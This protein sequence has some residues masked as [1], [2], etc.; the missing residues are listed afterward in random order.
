M[1]LEKQAVLEY[2][3]NMMAAEL[4]GGKIGLRCDYSDKIVEM[5]CFS[6]NLYGIIPLIK[7][8]FGQSDRYIDYVKK[9]LV[10]GT[11]PKSKS[12]WG[13]YVCPDQRVCESIPIA[14]VLVFC[15]NEIWNTLN[16]EEKNNIVTWLNQV[17]TGTIYDSNWLFF[18]I[19]VNSCLKKLDVNYCDDLLEDSLIRVNKLYLGNGWYQDGRLRRIDYY[20]A[21]A[22]HFYGLLFAYLMPE[23]KYSTI[24]IERA[25][26]FSQEFILLSSSKGD[27]VP[28]GRSLTYK[29]AE[30]CFWSVQVYTGI[31]CLEPK[32]VKGIIARHFDFWKDKQIYNSQGIIDVGYT[33]LNPFMTEN[34]NNW[35]SS[36]WALKFFL[37]A[38]VQGDD[39]WS[40]TEA[41]LPELPGKKLLRT[42]NMIICS[43]V[44]RSIVT[45]F[46]NNYCAGRE[47]VLNFASKYMK[48][49]Y[50]NSFGFSVPRANDV[51]ERG[52]FDNVLAISE[53]GKY[54][55]CR[56]ELIDC[57]SNDDYLYS[58]YSPVSGVTIESY[59][60]PSFPW[61]VRIHRI[62]TNKTLWIKDAGS[63]INNDCVHVEQ[64]SDSELHI[65]DCDNNE[66]GTKAF[67]DNVVVTRKINTSNTNLINPR[68]SML[69]CEGKLAKGEH[70]ICT[71][72][73]NNTTA[74][75]KID[76]PI[77]EIN[78]NVIYIKFIDKS[79]TIHYKNEIASTNAMKISIRKYA[80]S[81]KQLIKRRK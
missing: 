63:S 72:F 19:I 50:S 26:K 64:K 40:L 65:V 30:G 47:I 76:P 51:Y 31:Y 28:Y 13:N 53:D 29:M 34:Y 73:Y 2:L 16:D 66:V 48:F 61:H 70:L 44:K 74:D 46:P 1:T 27:M 20:N 67:S 6:R 32:I 41:P 62:I 39:F 18:R 42:C 12:F 49:M 11:N 75:K 81:I 59:I 8:K 5:E 60:V 69:V 55:R 36:N 37:F 78:G 52:G 15:K 33:Y 4:T 3:D 58:K 17:N 71:A 45:L 54:Y 56:E 23:S 9:N 79:V 77:C 24:F 21:F 80:K 10:N 43:D 68:C 22:F 14:L 35:A 25:R 7:N 38:A 57:K